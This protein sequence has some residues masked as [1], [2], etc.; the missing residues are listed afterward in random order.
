MNQNHHKTSINNTS[1][2]KILKERQEIVQTNNENDD[3][4][5]SNIQNSALKQN[6]LKNTSILNYFDRQAKNNPQNA[7]STSDSSDKSNVVKRRKVSTKNKIEEQQKN[8]KTKNVTKSSSA[9]TSFSLSSNS[10]FNDD[11]TSSSISSSSQQ[12]LKSD[13]SD[14]MNVK[15]RVGDWVYVEL[16]PFQ[17]YSIRRIEEFTRNSDGSLE[18]KLRCAFRRTDIPTH[19]LQMLEKHY[20]QYFTN[21]Q[22]TLSFTSVKS[23]LQTFNNNQFNQ[24]DENLNQNGSQ[25][26]SLTDLSDM[27]DEDKILSFLQNLSPIQIH[28][29]KHRELFYSKYYES[30]V[31]CS[32]FRGKVNLNLFVPDVNTFDE[33]LTNNRDKFFYQIAYDPNKNMISEDKIMIRVGAKFQAEIPGLNS[34]I[35]LTA[36][37]KRPIFLMNNEYGEKEFETLVWDGPKNESANSDIAMKKYL[38]RM[39]DTKLKFNENQHGCNEISETRDT[40]MVIF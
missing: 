7:Y 5:S 32:L 25:A 14:N 38:K 13:I 10:K 34:S 19:L 29:L 2:S 17:P 6:R 40:I 30:N 1:N 36:K 35:K 24:H 23:D 37:R 8:Q 28:H 16:E 27:S 4:D 26:S 33:Y 18:A 12:T 3:D 31:S 20:A 39:I 15:Y 22:S 21:I 9:S 11:E